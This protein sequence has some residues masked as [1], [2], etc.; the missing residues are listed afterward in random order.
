MN[1]LISIQQ[2]VRAWQI[3]QEAVDTLRERFP[4]ITFIHATSDD[5]RAQALPDCDVAFTWIL[6]TSELNAARR[7]RWVHSSAVAVETLCLP[8]LFAR[9]V[10][11]SNSRGV[12]SRPVAEH[13]IAVVLALVKQLPLALER[14]RAHAWAQNDF[15]GARL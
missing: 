5:M 4:H 3:P 6:S 9:N 12:Q 14:Q 10:V 2:P 8:E 1:V 15:S 13:T 11:V 7:L